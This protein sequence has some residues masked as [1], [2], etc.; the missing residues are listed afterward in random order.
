MSS[1]E[2]P[3]RPSTRRLQVKTALFLFVMVTMGP[4]GNVLLRAGMRHHA[5]HSSLNPLVLYHEFHRFLANIDLWLGI[6]SR[7]ISAAAFMCLLSWADYSYVNPAASIACVIVV[8]LGWALLGEF[9]PPGR[10]IGAVLI[11]LG[12]LLIGLT[13]ARTT[14]HAQ[15]AGDS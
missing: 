15:G 14:R 10:W 3:V 1:I 12:V 5:V 13:P 9:V 11:C 4:L 7:I 8:F 2:L 6:G